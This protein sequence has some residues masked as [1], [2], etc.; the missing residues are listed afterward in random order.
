MCYFIMIDHRLNTFLT[1]CELKSYT[2]AAKK[3]FITQPAVSQQIKYL[4]KHYGVNLF[5][6]EGKSLILT[7]AGKKLQSFALT[8][9]NDCE[10]ITQQLSNNTQ[11]PY[12]KFGS[13]LTIGQYVMPDI[14]EYILKENQHTSLSMIVDNTSA[15]LKLLNE[16]KID[17]A[18]IEGN[19][20]K[21]E[22]G[23]ELFS[24]EDFIGI[25]HPQS[26]YSKGLHSLDDLFNET[27][28]LR[29]KGSG[30]RDVFEQLLY[31][32][33][34]C[35]DSFKSV[36]E[37]GS[38]PAILSLVSSNCGISF[39]Y[40]RAAQSSVNSNQISIINIKGLPIKREFNFVWLKNSRFASL[41]HDFFETCRYF[42]SK[43]SL[44]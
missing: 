23:Y 30:T 10:K 42:N 44:Q 11:N 4:E 27:L 5:K 39:M 33:N 17:F 24:M 22:Y 31:E 6:Y 20:N 41:Y 1:L 15:L 14:I 9:V 3:L 18:I 8:L 36:C 29:E 26:K 12:F 40:K 13:T 43:K 16:G 25:C 37:I 7:P 34:L 28:I 21:S 2:K 32:Q 38:L 19:F 35:I